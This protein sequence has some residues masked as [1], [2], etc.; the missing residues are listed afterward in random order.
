MAKQL[1]FKGAFMITYLTN[2]KL[3]NNGE[4]SIQRSDNRMHDC[5]CINFGLCNISCGSW[6][7]QFGNVTKT[8]D[9]SVNR[10]WKDTMVS[11][12]LTICQNKILVF[13]NFI[14]EL[15]ERK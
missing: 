5:W 10:P 3:N 9:P 1:T 15:S 13:K 8:V 14:D 2:G 11:Y 7:P 6:C 12:R 4:L